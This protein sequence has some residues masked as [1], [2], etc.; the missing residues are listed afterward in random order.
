[1][2]GFTQIAYATGLV[3]PQSPGERVPRATQSVE[4]ERLLRQVVEN[5]G[6]SLASSKSHSRAAV[7]AAT[8][9]EP[10][11]V[12]GIDIEWIA[13]E[14]PIRGIARSLLGEEASGIGLN[15]FY[16]FWTFRES[17]FKAFQ[18][19]PAPALA[20]EFLSTNAT[21][22]IHRLECGVNVLEHRFAADVF[23][24]CLVWSG[25]AHIPRYLDQTIPS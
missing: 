21:S 2:Q 20:F 5:A 13:R 8:C 11:V 9:G 18:C 3:R 10:G 14:R 16:R 25:P 17:Y 15:D 12:I 4:A 19:T 7:A 6:L 23:Q 24:L 1:M 22:A